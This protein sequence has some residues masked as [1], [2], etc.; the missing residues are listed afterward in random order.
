LRDYA[1]FEEVYGG[2]EITAIKNEEYI[3]GG[4][5]AKKI[6]LGALDE[7]WDES[8]LDNCKNVSK[9]IYRK[10]KNELMVEQSTAYRYTLDAR[11]MLYGKPFT[12]AGQ[13]GQC[14][15]L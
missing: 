3:K 12:S 10:H 4:S 7:E 5:K 6:I 14:I 13:L 15:Y 8:G 2:I 9:K 1:D 11:N